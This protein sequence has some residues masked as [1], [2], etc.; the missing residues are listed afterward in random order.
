MTINWSED[1]LSTVLSVDRCELLLQ[2]GISLRPDLPKVRGRR[3]SHPVV[4]WALLGH[5]VSGSVLA[6]TQ[7]GCG[8]MGDR[9][10]TAPF[11]QEGLCLIAA[12]GLA[13][14]TCEHPSKIAGDPM[15]IQI[16]FHEAKSGTHLLMTKKNFNEGSPPYQGGKAA[17]NHLGFSVS[18][19]IAATNGLHQNTT[20]I[21]DAWT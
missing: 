6:E 15:D 11:S 20:K 16:G 2:T 8:L 19:E 18:L 3:K 10:L 12:Q 1:H 4:E 17:S 13:L 7:I 14:R 21:G 9:R 5:A